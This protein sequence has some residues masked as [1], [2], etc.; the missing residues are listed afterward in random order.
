MERTVR[1]IAPLALTLLAMAALLM[2]GRT[3][4]LLFHAVAEM[5]S[6]SVGTAIFAI[7]WNSQ[8]YLQN[9]YLIF[10]G[11][12]SGFVAVIDLLHTLAYDGM[13][14]FPGAGPNLPTQLW[15]AA[16][17]VQSLAFL[18]APVF[19]RVRERAL[20][21]LGVLVGIAGLLLASIFAWQAFP[22]AYLP[23]QGLTAFKISSE[24]VIIAAFTASMALLI[25]Q[26]R[27]FDP[28]VLRLLAAAIAFSI[29][30]D[31]AFMLYVSVYDWV[32]MLGHFFKITAF[33]LLYRAIVQTGIEQPLRSI[34][35][36]LKENEAALRS[37]EARLED[38]VLVRTRQL[39]EQRALLETVLREAASGIVVT[40]AQ[41][42]VTFANDAART[43]IQRDDSLV[44]EDLSSWGAVLTAAGERI[45]PHSWLHEFSQS[46]EAEIGQELRFVHPDGHISD[47]IGS[48][49]PLHSAG[50][51]LSGMVIVLTDITERRQAEEALRQLNVELEQRV[52]N[53]TAEL[54][55]SQ[56]RLRRLAESNVVGIATIQ[57]DGALLAANDAVL[58]MLGY[59]R[60]DLEQHRIRWDAITPPDFAAMDARAFQEA[61]ETG[62]CTPYEKDLLHQDGRRVPILTAF[63]S[64]EGAP[65]QYIAY[66]IDISAQKLAEDAMQRYAERLERSNRELQEFAYVASH[67][68]QEPLRK[69]IA[70]GERLG[71]SATSRLDET[72]ADYLRRMQRAAE[73]MRNMID[74]LLNLSRVTT[75]AQP[76]QMVDL[77]KAMQDVLAD[78]E[79]RIETSGAQIQLEPLPTLHADPLQMRQLLLNLVGNAIKFARPDETPRVEISG[80]VT[81]TGKQR[82]VYLRVCDN[83]I[84]IEPQYYE[85][86]FQPFQRLHGA[87]KYE[88]SGMGLAIVQKIVERHGGKIQVESAPGHGSTFTVQLPDR[89]QPG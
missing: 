63:A 21:Y 7:T 31:V 62:T 2:I 37:S 40:D 87:N 69:I 44:G 71:E 58:H 65:G 13:G 45:N 86:I 18:L 11:Y 38:Q 29:L 22:V 88:G 35:R 77:N 16:R 25:A 72:E 4:Y 54:R 68:L 26:R 75:Q 56:A 12:A 15:L 41:G 55:L 47:L 49:S 23:G 78:L 52:E 89:A 20:Y 9:G 33:F 79:F 5:I 1:N 30:T 82:Q 51:A 67:D 57:E 6:I 34:F 76:F 8:R 50:G 32:N 42:N 43:F 28:H 14:V 53:R 81:E 46:A 24:Y 3:N 70:F 83:G 80:G 36:E 27:H 39:D 48:I 60:Q 66:V 61:R 64:L 84:G 73:R 74:A 85:R 10:I 19:L 59:T 17:Y